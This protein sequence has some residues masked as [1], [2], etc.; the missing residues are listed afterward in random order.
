MIQCAISDVRDC[1]D[2]DVMM[3]LPLA[4]RIYVVVDR[5]RSARSLVATALS[6]LQLPATRIVCVAAGAVGHQSALK[7]DMPI[8]VGSSCISLSYIVDFTALLLLGPEPTML[9]AMASAWSQ[10]TFR[11]KER[12]PPHR[13]IFSMASLVADACWVGGR[14]YHLAGRNAGIAAVQ[15]RCSRCSATVLTY[16]LVNSLAVAAAFGLRR[17]AADLPR[18]ARQLP[19]ERDELCGWRAD[20][21]P[22]RRTDAADRAVADAAGV[23]AAACSRI[24]PIGSI[25]HASPTSSGAPPSR[26]S[27]IAR[28]PKCW[29]GRSRRKT[30]PA[31][32][33]SIGSATTR[34]CSRAGCSCPSSIQQALETAALLHDIGKLAVPEHILSKPGPLTTDE[35][36]KM[37]IHAQVGA[38]I[39]NA[40][41]FPRPGRATHSQPP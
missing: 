8:G 22:R 4:G 23:R 6:S 31:P 1:A 15:R 30:G 14:T 28:A 19:V 5:L 2:G 21:G 25:S 34:Q 33:I 32:A 36:Q 39:V 38:G 26:A 41:S 16:F 40:V 29:R 20:R 17:R 7:V 35:R 37:Q 3:R 9:I 13:T 12:N 24:E 18:L 27:C 11:M 10:C